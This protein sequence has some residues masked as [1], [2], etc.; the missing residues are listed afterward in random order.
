MFG[1]L[2]RPENS[3]LLD[4]SRREFG[5]LV[6]VVV[7]IIIMG[8]YPRPFLKTMEASVARTMATVAAGTDAARRVG[9]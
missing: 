3:R 4:L 2:T 7:L 1:P 5:V 8:V 6:P 9:R